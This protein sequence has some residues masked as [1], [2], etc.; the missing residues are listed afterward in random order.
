MLGIA[1]EVKA[2]GALLTRVQRYDAEGR[3]TDVVHMMEWGQKTPGIP[4][5]SSSHHRVS[6]VPGPGADQN[7]HSRSLGC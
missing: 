2:T 4:E 1:D 5:V 6:F 7:T 3:P